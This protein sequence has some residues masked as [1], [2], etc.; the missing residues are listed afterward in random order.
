M[1]R[2]SP[3]L[4]AVASLVREGA[5]L[6]DVGTD[7]AQLPAALM[8]CG[9]IRG[10]VASDVNEGPVAHARETV[11]ACGFEGQIDVL[12]TDGLAG[13]EGYAPTDIVIAGMGGELIRDIL[14][15]SPIPKKSGVR[16][17][18]Q[19]MT[20]QRELRE[21][22]S[23]G[24]FHISRE[25]LSLDSNLNG[26]LYNILCAEYRAD[27]AESPYSE[28]ELVVGRRLIEER[29]AHFEA[30][31]ARHLEILDVRIGGMDKAGLDTSGLKALRWDI[32]ALL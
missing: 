15:A 12:L 6:A 23:T 25:L 10:A 2:L 16:L 22:L 21:Y 1:I 17:I 20:M 28:L 14:A 18:L 31:I 24:H 9:K 27:D 5:F 13:L 11:R 29:P 7:H 19:P 32:A 30:Y 4:A 8:E 3:R 26:R